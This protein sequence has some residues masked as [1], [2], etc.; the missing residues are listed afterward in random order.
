MPS[1]NTSLEEIFSDDSSFYG[2]TLYTS[3][4]SERSH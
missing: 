2:N 4:I 3:N 1:N